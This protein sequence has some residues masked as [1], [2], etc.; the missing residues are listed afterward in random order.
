MN[1][2]RNLKE[3]GYIQFQSMREISNTINVRIMEISSGVSFYIQ[4]TLEPKDKHTLS[5]CA[6]T[7]SSERK[8]ELLPFKK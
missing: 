7:L 2:T 5:I 3:L 6:Y 8:T 4:F 1:V